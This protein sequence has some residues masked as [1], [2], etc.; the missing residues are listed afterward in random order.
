MDA[1]ELIERRDAGREKVVR[2]GVAG[3]RLRHEFE[4]QG[5]LTAV[6]AGPDRERVQALA[7][8][9]PVCIEEPVFFQGDERSAA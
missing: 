3:E 7:S 2:L 8:T 4:G 6:A 1:H 5:E 9:H